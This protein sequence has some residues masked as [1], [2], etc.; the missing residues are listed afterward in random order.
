MARTIVIFS[1][2]YAPSMGGVELY[3]ASLARELAREGCRSVVVTSDLADSGAYEKVDGV[4]IWRL[5]C[6]SLAGG[7]LPL[8][9]PNREYRA[10]MRRLED[11]RPS[12]VVVQTRFYPLSLEGLSYARRLGIRPVVIDHGSDYLGFGDKRI[13]WLVRSY[14][15]AITA[16]GRLGAADYYGVSQMSATWLET[17]GIQARGTISN[18]VD[19]EGF[20]SC[21]SGRDF[22]A[23]LEIFLE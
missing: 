20:R 23:E 5:P 18:A 17:F 19:A 11:L 14:E 2:L 9:T 16:A 22:H 21:A 7:R 6:K 3:T 1:A 8:V 12:G 10:I 13:D 4:E 15:R